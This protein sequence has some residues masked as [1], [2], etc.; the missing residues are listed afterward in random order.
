MRYRALVLVHFVV[1]R[2]APSD[3]HWL[4]VPQADLPFQ[5]VTWYSNMSRNGVPVGCSTMS[6]ELPSFVGDPRWDADDEELIA[7]AA[8][9]LRQ[10]DLLARGDVLHA[11]VVRVPRA[12]PMFEMGAADRAAEVL[13]YLGDQHPDVHATG[14]QARFSY[15]NIDHCIHFATELATRM[16]VRGP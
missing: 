15:V 13:S 8:A 3:A 1:G 10:L 14:R 11:A 9:G 16:A 4:Y 7:E 6:V 2:E 5:R 12:Y